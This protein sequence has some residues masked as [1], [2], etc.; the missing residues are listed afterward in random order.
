M[1]KF[2]IED[3]VRRGGPFLVGD[4]GGGL[5]GPVFERGVPRAT[6]RNERGAGDERDETN[7]GPDALRRGWSSSRFESTERIEA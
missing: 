7:H 6:N 2:P 4:E 5:I 1:P 3:T